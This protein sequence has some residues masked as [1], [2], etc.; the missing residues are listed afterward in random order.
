MEDGLQTSFTASQVERVDIAIVCQ[1]IRVDCLRLH[2]ERER[3][4]FAQLIRGDSAF[5]APA[6]ICAGH[7]GLLRVV[8]NKDSEDGMASSPYSVTTHHGEPCFTI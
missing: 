8:A 2:V 6:V 1:K 5:G 7:Q 3:F 4:V